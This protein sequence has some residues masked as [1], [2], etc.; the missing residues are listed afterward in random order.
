[1]SS[2]KPACA[3]MSSHELKNSLLRRHK[4]VIPKIPYDFERIKRFFMNPKGSENFLNDSKRF[5]RIQQTP[6]GSKRLHKY[7]ESFQMIP[8]DF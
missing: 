1:M 7:H 6:K 2:H 5:K 8:K 4:N 3:K